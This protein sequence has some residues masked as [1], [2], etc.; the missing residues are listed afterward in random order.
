MEAGRRQTSAGICT[1]QSPV[2][3][4]GPFLRAEEK[5][6][7]QPRRERTIELPP[8]ETRSVQK[9]AGTRKAVARSKAAGPLRGKHKENM[10]S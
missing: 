4:S 6:V 2:Q 5:R 8:L 7:Q 9:A 1:S 3:S 10:Y